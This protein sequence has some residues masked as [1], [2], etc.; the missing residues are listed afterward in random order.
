MQVDAA[1]GEVLD[2]LEERGLA[3]QT[4]V[5]FTSDN[6]CSPEAKFPELLARGHDPSRG[7]RGHKADIFEGG[8]R[9]PFL[10]RWPGVVAPGR[11]SDQL[12]CLTDLMATCAEVLG[13]RLPDAAGEDSV[14]I[15]PAL[16]RTGPPSP[17]RGGGAPFDQRLLRHPT[18]RLEAR[19]CP[20]SGGWSGPRPGTEEA[21]GLPPIQLYNL[22]SDPG[23][24]TNVQEQHPD[25][26]ARLDAPPREVRD[27][28]TQ[29]A[30]HA[31]EE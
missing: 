16:R 3:E 9:V 5:I 11:R 23:E 4:L 25:E 21:A 30:G 2:A 24:R 28:W 19:L 31:A 10:V 6:G 29:H 14:S 17:P 1:V 13:E 15:L 26:A 18:G 12:I 22:A 7:F 27:R 20:D 8:H